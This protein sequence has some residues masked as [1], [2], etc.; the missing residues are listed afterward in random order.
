MKKLI[1][2]LF[3]TLLGLYIFNLILSDDEDS[4]KSQGRN[5]MQNQID[6]YKIIP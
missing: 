6:S 5:I 4:I 1:I 2:I 3:C